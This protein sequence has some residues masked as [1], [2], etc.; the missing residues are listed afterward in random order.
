MTHSVTSATPLTLNER[1]GGGSQ[2]IILVLGLWLLATVIGTF[3]ALLLQESALSDGQFVPRTND[4]F[5]HARRILDAAVGERGF[6]EFDDRIHAPDGRWIP[7]PWAYDYM[8]AKATQ[9]ALWFRPNMDPM[10]F[11]AHVPVSWVAVNTAL[12]LFATGALGLSIGMRA[13]A[14]LAFALSPL[15][16]QI[17]SI[18]MID[19]HYME[20]TFVLLTIWLGLL[21]FKQ[22]DK[23]KPAA[24]LG[25]ALGLAPAFHNGLFVLQIPVLACGLLLWLRNM[26]PPKRSTGLFS[27]FLIGGT[28]VAVLPSQT[29]RAGLF[30]FGLLS[31][32]HLYVAACTALMMTYIA[33]DSFST[34]RLGG[35]VGLGLL[36]IIPIIAQAL[37]GMAF[38]TSNISIL[39]DI[40]EAQ[41]PWRMFTEILTPMETAGLY[42][43][44]ILAAP[45]LLAFF[46][47]RVIRENEPHRLFYALMSVF[48]LGLMLLQYRF[49]YFGLFVLLT[50]GLYLADQLTKRFDWNRAAVFGGALGLLALA[51]QPALR[52]Q[53]FTIYAVGADPGYAYAA[54]L[55]KTLADHCR[56]EP[57]IVLADHNDGNYI[58]YHT[59]C[60]VIS[61]NFILSPEDDA[62]IG[63]I[64]ALMH[65][66]PEAIRDGHPQIR[67][68][69]LRAN[70]F[71]ANPQF[72]R[73]LA[74]NSP[75]ASALL[76]ENARGADGYELL[77]TT[78]MLYPDSEEPEIYARIFK[79]SLPLQPAGD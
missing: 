75:V 36:M 67:Y 4:S 23:L 72:S 57:G 74:A 21:W 8:M 28:L 26:A 59:D 29:F 1:L 58:L 45:V 76:T 43:W 46:A 19:H 10:A 55:Y 61:N 7:W 16:Q 18:A 35:L 56:E 32:F 73:D 54:P 79:I 3:F 6:Y 62:K 78:R 9:L 52:N 63:E 37:R 39:G 38:M 66:S 13:I 33:R 64:S 47:W 17:H 31:G 41:S 42:S 68:V 15:T 30:D 48:G 14:M 11:I 20:H 71:F 2:R 27:V 24:G 60:S 51:Y 25:L 70:D 50:G 34:R 53:L 22:P 44:M 40:A 5:Y 12:F 49:H 69:M 77:E 65:M